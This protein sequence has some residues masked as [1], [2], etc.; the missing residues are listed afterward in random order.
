MDL[1]CSD[2]TFEQVRLFVPRIDF[3]WAAV[4]KEVWCR[5]YKSSHRAVSD[6][7]FFWLHIMIFSI[8]LKSLRTKS[9]LALVRET[10]TCTHHFLFKQVGRA[11]RTKCSNLSANTFKDLC[12]ANQNNLARLS[13]R[14]VFGLTLHSEVRCDFLAIPS[15]RKLSI[16]RAKNRSLFCEPFV[17]TV[18]TRMRLHT[19]VQETWHSSV[20][21]RMWHEANLLPAWREHKTVIGRLTSVNFE[22]AYGSYFWIAQDAGNACIAKSTSRVIIRKSID[23]K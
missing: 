10:L 3:R 22:I 7:E 4:R 16:Y 18:S 19:I 14:I 12:E 23:R 2:A 5:R 6:S 1:I 20:W 21:G 17:T 8:V 13:Q 15:S 11:T 9:N